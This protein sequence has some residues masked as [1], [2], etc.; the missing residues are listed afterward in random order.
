DAKDDVDGSQKAG[1][2]GILVQTGKYR[3]G[4]E[5][6]VDPGAYGVCKDFPAAVEK[7]LEHNAT[8]S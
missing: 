8:C 1:L 6:K 4:D 7:I 5:S 3:S 2:R